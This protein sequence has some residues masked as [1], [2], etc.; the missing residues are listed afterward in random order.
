LKYNQSKEVVH[1]KQLRVQQL[2]LSDGSIAA[3]LRLWLHLIALLSI[4]L[5]CDAVV[6]VKVKERFELL[7]LC[8]C[9]SVMDHKLLLL[10]VTALSA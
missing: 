7:Q 1:L 8:S 3:F 9:C 2:H 5:Y 6:R 4:K 10:I